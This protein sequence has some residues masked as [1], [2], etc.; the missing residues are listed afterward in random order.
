M[1]ENP[2]I[3]DSVGA[4]PC[5]PDVKIMP[6]TKSNF[7]LCWYRYTSTAEVAD[8]NNNLAPQTMGGKIIEYKYISLL[9][10]IPISEEAKQVKDKRNLPAEFPSCVKTCI[11]EMSCGLACSACRQPTFRDPAPLRARD[12]VPVQTYRIFLLRLLR[13]FHTAGFKFVRVYCRTH[14]VKL[15]C[16]LRL[17]TR[18]THHQRS[19]FEVCG[20]FVTP[21]FF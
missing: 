4:P 17:L 1:G 6:K 8:G 12:D 5:S 9:F 20:I 2:S 14:G 3:H 15:Y 11:I 13:R 7:N 18:R 10:P 19:I 16:S 21:V